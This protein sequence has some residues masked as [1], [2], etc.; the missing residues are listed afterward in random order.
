MSSNDRRLL[1]HATVVTLGENCRVIHDGALLLSG[2]LVEELGST[3]ELA[4]KH[5]DLSAQ[6]LQGKVVMPGQINAHTH[7]YSAFARGISLK[8][9]PPENF[10][11]ILERLWW[12]MDAALTLE[13]VRYSGLLGYIEAVKRGTTTMIDHHAS[14]GAIAGSLDELAQGAGLVGVRGCFCYEVTDRHGPEGAR[15]GIEENV[16][17]LRK[18][19]GDG[20][21]AATFG[22]HAPITVGQ[23]TL[24]HCLEA[25]DPA[26]VFHVHVAE[27]ICDCEYSQEHFGK[28]PLERLLAEGLA[29]RPLMAGHC[30]HLSPKE[31]DLL[32]QNPITVL[33]NPRSNMNNA[34]GCAPVPEFLRRGIPVGC[35]TDGMSQDPSQDLRMIALIHKH[36]VGHPQAFSY[37]DVYK[38]CYSNNSQLASRFFGLKLGSI[39]PGAAADLMVVDYDPPTPLEDGNVM[40]HLLFGM[41]VAPVLTTIVG[42]QDVYRD[43]KV[44]GVDE[45]EVLAH[46]REL[47]NKLWQRW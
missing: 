28:G 10:L 47:A 42:G 20:R 9:A 17:F 41:G 21:L 6:S 16:R 25:A 37:G 4:A 5:P 46:C 13:D 8:D 27:D 1:T 11:Q 22:L 7:L 12:R 19:R 39:E 14:P 45:K 34:V 44:L 15:Q 43:G 30:N 29:G 2:G 31:V 36:Q 26:D 24:R 32:T 38:I 40:G 18:C 3:A 35:G 33:H 23:E